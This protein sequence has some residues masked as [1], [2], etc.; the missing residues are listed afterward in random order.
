[1][2]RVCLE[3]ANFKLPFKAHLGSHKN[4]KTIVILYLLNSFPI[5]VKIVTLFYAFYG[6]VI[7]YRKITFIFVHSFYRLTFVMTWLHTA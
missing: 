7:F 4:F 5:T 6:M 2:K 1:V 3:M